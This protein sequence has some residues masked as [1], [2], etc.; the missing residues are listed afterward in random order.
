MDGIVLDVDRSEMRD[1]QGWCADGFP[2]LPQFFD[3]PLRRIAGDQCSV[4]GTDRNAGNPIRVE[5]GFRESLVD[6][7]LIGA[8]RPSA[9]QQQDGLFEPATFDP[10]LFCRRRGIHHR[11]FPCGC[12]FAPTCAIGTTLLSGATGLCFAWGAVTRALI[13]ICGTSSLTDRNYSAVDVRDLCLHATGRRRICSRSHSHSP[14]RPIRHCPARGAPGNPGITHRRQR[15]TNPGFRR[16]HKRRSRIQR[17]FS[18]PEKRRAADDGCNRETD[19]CDRCTG[20]FFAPAVTVPRGSSSVSARSPKATFFAPWGALNAKA[21]A[22]TSVFQSLMRSVY[23]GAPVTALLVMTYLRGTG[24][25]PVSIQI[26]QSVS[27][28][29]KARCSHSTPSM[30]P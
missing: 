5:V 23:W 3:T 17:H 13:A 16:R 22:G 7:S 25:A 1:T 11:E 26:C 20:H 10:K 14:S 24:R 8:E 9:L 18:V 12:S 27:A 30:T 4:H 15:A 28:F 6:A 19:H 21:S 2:E 29:R